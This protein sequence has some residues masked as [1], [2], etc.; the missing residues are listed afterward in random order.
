MTDK[1]LSL[2]YNNECNAKIID[3]SKA[4]EYVGWLDYMA[5]IL[6]LE[7]NW[8]ILPITSV[9]CWWSFR[10]WWQSTTIVK[11]ESSANLA[12]FKKRGPRNWVIPPWWGRWSKQCMNI[13]WWDITELSAGMDT[14]MWNAM[15]HC[16]CLPSYQEQPYRTVKLISLKESPLGR[17]S[18]FEFSVLAF[19][20]FPLCVWP[21]H[22]M[23]SQ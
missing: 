22:W 12:H 6:D 10:L 23:S 16:C 4:I 3:I 15:V 18:C 14:G 8:A 20:L 13:G 1:Y 5:A 17:P 9:A 19:I 7:D 2:K 11:A 21:S